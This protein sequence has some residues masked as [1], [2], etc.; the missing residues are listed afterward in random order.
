MEALFTQTSTRGT[1]Y[2]GGG[3]GESYWRKM[4]L[5]NRII[6][7]ASDRSVTDS[8]SDAKEG[9]VVSCVD[10]IETYKAQVM[11]QP[12]LGFSATVVL[13]MS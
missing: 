2:G 10:A 3:E 7:S 9:L 13:S 4:E 1:S 12:W 5:S 6:I 11:G 8:L